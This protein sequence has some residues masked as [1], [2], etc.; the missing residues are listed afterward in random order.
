ML[1][2]SERAGQQLFAWALMNAFFICVCFTRPAYGW[3]N[4]EWVPDN[5]D[6]KARQPHYNDILAEKMAHEQLVFEEETQNGLLN[7]ALNSLSDPGLSLRAEPGNAGGQTLG[8]RFLAGWDMLL[9]NHWSTGPVAQ[10]APGQSRFNCLQCEFSDRAS[11]DAIA[12]VGW[13]IDSSFG[14]MSPWIQLSYSYQ[15]GENNLAEENARSADTIGQHEDNWLDI[16]VGAHM[17][18][19]RRVAAFATFSQTGALSSDEQFIYSLGVS[20]SF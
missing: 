17:P 2:K 6:G 4:A 18:I 5:P 12:S 3:E 1:Q 8:T 10:Y 13:R 16:S 7:A 19:N 20:A 9:N 14:W 11:P 15:F